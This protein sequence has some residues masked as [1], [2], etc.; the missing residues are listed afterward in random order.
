MA[1]AGRRTFQPGEVLTASN[2]NSYLMDQSVMRFASSAAR[3]SAV[4]TAVIAEGMVS[5][6]D[7]TNV[8]EVYDGSA[9]N[10]VYTPSALPVL[11]GGTGG[12]TVAAAQDNLGVGLVNIVPSSVT[13][14][15]SGSSASYDSTSG[16]ITFATCTSLNVDGIFTS[17]YSR[18]KAIISIPSFTTLGGGCQIRLRNAGVDN[19]SSN[20]GQS[21]AYIRANGNVAQ[22]SGTGNTGWVFITG[23]NSSTGVAFV[24]A[25]IRGLLQNVRKSAIWLG[26]GQDSGTVYANY[27]AAYFNDTTKT[28][29]GIT[30]LYGGSGNFGGT[31]QFFGY[32]E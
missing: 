9:W 30:F 12:T 5:Y 1:G 6:L 23:D 26:Q 31:I 25:D 29:D 3:G 8:L 20:Y 22:N 14:V 7:D 16:L 24:S 17:T 15:G 4:G 18:Y 10:T 28:F 32:R 27:G 19:T 11:R 13:P 21:V 2:V